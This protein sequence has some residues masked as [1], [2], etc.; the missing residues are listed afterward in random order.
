MPQAERTNMLLG[1]Q[2]RA[3][4][5][6][7]VLALGAALLVGSSAGQ[8]AAADAVTAKNL[9][10]KISTAKTAA[11]HKVIAAYYQ[12]EAAKAKAKVTEHQE[13]LEA[14]KKAG[15]G[16]VAKS[17]NQPGTIEHCNHLIKSYRDLAESLALMAKAHEEMAASTK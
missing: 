3:R 12:A 9:K 6:G 4:F 8:A 17:P 11:D 14:Y 10:Q 7:F 16:T 1:R 5:P 2:I 13:M 15:V